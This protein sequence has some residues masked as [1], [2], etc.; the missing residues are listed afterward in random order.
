MTAKILDHIK[1]K[2]AVTKQR[3]RK[4]SKMPPYFIFK[5]SQNEKEN[6]RKDKKLWHQVMK[7]KIPFWEK[8]R[9]DQ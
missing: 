2:L 4:D 1:S 3:N 9:S 6:Q 8:L 7:R 5:T